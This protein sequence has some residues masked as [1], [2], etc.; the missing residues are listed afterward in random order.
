MIL[1]PPG[2]ASRSWTTWTFTA[3]ISSP[4][5]RSTS[6]VPP[7]PTGGPTPPH[8][9]IRRGRWRTYWTINDEFVETYFS[10]GKPVVGRLFTNILG[11]GTLVEIVGVVGN[12]L[13]NGPTDRPQP[14]FYVPLGNHGAVNIGREIN[15]VARTTGDPLALSQPIRDIVRALDR[16]AAVH[17]MNAL[18]TEL[19]AV[20]GEPRFAASMLGAFAAL[21]LGLAGVGLYAILSYGVSRRRREL[22]VR[23]AL[24]ASSSD[25]VALIVREG[26]GVTVAGLVV[27]LIAAAAVTRLMRALLVGV[28][29][30]DL[31]S[32][33]TATLVLLAVALAACLIP[34][35]RQNTVDPV[36]AL[37]CE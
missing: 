24:G 5:H 8:G 4:C 25:L 29:P 16:A 34:A 28:G 18:S 21:A 30:T 33:A 26:M 9:V 10:D 11:P 12:V 1:P 20:V 2:P 19:S 3:A 7:A 13:K 14:E 35:W 36:V 22:A 6:S 37:K 32:F 15:I 31:V 23:T 17:N 27:G